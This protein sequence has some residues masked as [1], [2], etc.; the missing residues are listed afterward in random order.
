MATE[1][2]R[3][4]EDHKPG[5]GGVALLRRPIVV[6]AASLDPLAVAPTS[7]LPAGTPLGAVPSSGKYKPIRRTLADGAC[8]TSAATVPV[9]E[10]T[11][12]AVGDVVAVVPA[13]TPTVAASALGTIA[14]IVD[15][16]SITLGA[17]ATTAVTS[18]DII[19]V[20]EN[21]LKPDAVILDVA[22][23]L[24]GND[25]T[26]VDRGASGMVVGMI[27]KSA[28]NASA[29]KGIVLTRL[30]AEVSH[31]YLANASAGTV[32]AS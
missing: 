25:G 6:D 15:G 1:F 23:D 29:S 13:A 20:A 8:T 7:V 16:T 11:M 18:G 17:N 22:L 5:R 19:E 32:Q 28:L 4:Y 2:D 10:T 14:S 30:A 31:V 3:N 9:A 26:A 24:R 27:D 12:F 21:A